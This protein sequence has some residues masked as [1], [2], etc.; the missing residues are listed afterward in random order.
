[1]DQKHRRRRD[2]WQNIVITL[3]SFS[4]VVL[5]TQT[6][7]HSRDKELSAAAVSPGAVTQADSALTAPVRV[8]VSGSYGRYGS[9][10]LTTATAGP[11]FSPLGTLLGEALSSAQMYTACGREDFLAALSASSVY[12]DFLFPLPLSILGGFVG[13]E[14][15][16][17]IQARYLVVTGEGS[18]VLLY[19]WDG[20]ERF[21]TCPTALSADTLEGV[22]GVFEQGNA[23]FGFETEAPSIHPLSLFLPET[24]P[25]LPDLAAANALTSGSALLSALEFNPYTQT[26]WEEGGTEVIVDGGRTLRIRSDGS[27]SYRG[28]GSGALT[29]GSG[30]DLP[31]L[32]EA[33]SEIERLLRSLLSGKSL[34]TLYLKSISRSG[35]ATSLTF[36]YQYQG[37]PIRF[38]SGSPAAKVT[39]S[40]RSVASI[41]LTG[42]EY[43]PDGA[44]MLLPLRQALAIAAKSPGA[45]LFIGYADYAGDTVSPQW[46][47]E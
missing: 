42:R 20:G 35:S 28:G 19:L 12:Y 40:G 36:D 38:S 10:T 9:V 16:D 11:E 23:A 43:L 21:L 3:L 44:H 47:C 6:Q 1:M 29:I 37:V 30:E 22:I 32:W 31:S 46:L 24:E 2:F 33:A 25:D 8:A 41:A 26:R 45:E 7:F 39:L 18:R 27:L 17:S 4:A 13:A 15:E 34:G 5:F 14:G